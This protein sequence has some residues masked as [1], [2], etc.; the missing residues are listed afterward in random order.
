MFESPFFF[1]LPSVVQFGYLIVSSRK[2]DSARVVKINRPAA[3]LKVIA[4][5]IVIW[6]ILYLFVFM[7]YIY[8][9][10][11]KVHTRTDTLPSGN[12]PLN[13]HIHTPVL[14]RNE[15]AISVVGT[16]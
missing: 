5:E 1:L 11:V 15:N 6:K 12:S 8:K 14:C 13:A 2:N 9:K 3:F 10:K 16:N 7:V 4:K